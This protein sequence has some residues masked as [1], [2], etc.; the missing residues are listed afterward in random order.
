MLLIIALAA[1]PIGVVLHNLF[2]ALGTMIP[3][4]PVLREL[5]GFLE[6]IFF[7]VAVVAAGPAAVV[8][9]LGGIYTSWRGLTVLTKANRSVRRFIETHKITDK[10]MIRLVNLARHSA[11]GAN[12]Q[13]LKFV[14]SNSD[15]RN[16]LIFP[17]L[18]WAGYLSDWVGPVEGERPSGYIIVLGDQE[19]AK[20]FQYDAGIACQSITLGA[21]ELGLGGCLIGSIKKD[22][23][24]EALSI[25]ERYE[26]LLVIALG[27]PDETIILEDLEPEGDIKY[28]RDEKDIHHVPKR[29]L[30]ELILD[31]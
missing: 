21:V 14:L 13:P 4:V 28:W 11:S 3:S 30:G 9:L 6:V 7:L 15:E 23:L 2:Y 17:Y 5:V 18:S 22:A 25:P 16:D 20:N 19:V 8:A 26:I 27:K 10:E 24:R 31:W 12:L 29:E 1:F